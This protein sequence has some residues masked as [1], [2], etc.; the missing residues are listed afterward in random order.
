M[1]LGLLN[2]IV[3]KLLNNKITI[4][5]RSKINAKAYFNTCIQSFKQIYW[6]PTLALW[7]IVKYNIDLFLVVHLR[8]QPKITLTMMQGSLW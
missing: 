3:H 4:P 2:I 1:K 6:S 8:R 5:A 7:T